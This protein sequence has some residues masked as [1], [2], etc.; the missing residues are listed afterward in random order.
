MNITNRIVDKVTDKAIC[1]CKNWLTTSIEFTEDYSQYNKIT[2]YLRKINKEKFDKNRNP[3]TGSTCNY[4]TDDARYILKVDRLNFILVESGRRIHGNVDFKRI[5]LIFVGPNRYTIKEKFIKKA[6][7]KNEKIE[8]VNFNDERCMYV[9]VSPKNIGSIVMLP[10]HKKELIDVVHEWV[11]S[12]EWYLKHG[13]PYKLGIM[14]RGKPGTGKSTIARAISHMLGNCSIATVS[15]GGINHALVAI[16]DDLRYNK[17][18]F[19]IMLIE[20]IDMMFPNS[21]RDNSTDSSY[22]IKRGRSNILEKQ[23]ELFQVLDGILS[24]D[25]LIIIATTNCYDKLD[26]ALVRPGRFAIN[27]E[28]DYFNRDMALEMVNNF[29]LGEEFL[30]SLHLEYPVQPALLQDLI[31]EYGEKKG[32]K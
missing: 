4:L 21:N 5:K 17:D 27:I 12:K 1:G 18:K 30:D 28:L 22:E 24:M 23:R 32:D 19:Y 29:G 11:R 3:G 7:S 20:D 9:D 10:E 25:N 14:L 13:L 2:A 8:L 31:I 15:V 16:N 26:E 6:F